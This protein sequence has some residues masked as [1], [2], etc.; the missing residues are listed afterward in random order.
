MRP[1]HRTLPAAGLML[2]LAGVTPGLRAA[3][4]EFVVV[5]TTAAPEYRRTPG[6]DGVRPE[7]YVFSP[8]RH[9]GGATRDQSQEKM[10]FLTLAQTLAASLARQ[11]YF[12]AADPARANL[13]IIVH[14]GSTETYEDPNRQDNLAAT[15]QALSDYRAQ[16]AESG[17]ADPSRL[18][19]LLF[20][21]ETT[22]T[23]QDD[24]LN[25]N[26]ELL[27]YKRS[28][29][30]A[31]ERLYSSE[32]EST[33]RS[34]LGEERYFVVLM[35]YDYQ[36]LKKDKQSRLLWVTRMSVRSPGHNF[37]TAVP[38]MARIAADFYGQQRDGL[39]RR[40]TTLREGQVDIG[41]LKVIGPVPDL[42]PPA[43]SPE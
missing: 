30:Q 32:E 11:R 40:E 42:T 35:A 14:W 5:S 19:Q 31:G 7:S 33:M 17:I 20:D 8:G 29:R 23:R 16:I 13:V 9:F 34:E 27:G 41:E 2:A 26:A 15:S 10:P 1:L 4:G 6:P 38:G 36:R 24:F 39:T 12:P 3:G 28:L 43:Q 18:N 37:A 25:T 21:Q 22:A